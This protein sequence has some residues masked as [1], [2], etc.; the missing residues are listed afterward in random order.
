MVVLSRITHKS[1][2]VV[3]DIGPIF[4]SSIRCWSAVIGLVSYYH[5]LNCA[6]LF[7]IVVMVMASG[8]PDS[9]PPTKKNDCNNGKPFVNYLV[10]RDR[11]HRD[12]SFFSFGRVAGGK[13]RHASRSSFDTWCGRLFFF[14]YLPTFRKRNRE[15]HTHMH[16]ATKEKKKSVPEHDELKK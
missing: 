16:T 10:G 15:T 3:R 13:I 9:S 2:D 12:F 11:D 8:H 4:V 7:C 14:F 1:S 6:F 5:H